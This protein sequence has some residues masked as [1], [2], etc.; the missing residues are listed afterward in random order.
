MYMSWGM[1]Y[2]DFWHG[3]PILA[4]FYYEKHLIDIEQ[5]NQELWLQGLYIYDAL[6]VALNNSFSKQKQKYIS[7]PI[8]I[9]PKTEEE[10]QAEREATRQKM[11]ERLNAF[12]EEFNKR[13]AEQSE[14]E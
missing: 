8:R 2:E 4:S 14:T 5:R 10:L 3:K 9:I 6:A 12:A 13:H 1:S 11:V 7:E